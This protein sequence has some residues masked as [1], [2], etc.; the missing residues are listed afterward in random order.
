MLDIT[1]VFCYKAIMSKT[2]STMTEML[3]NAIK[4]SGLSAYRISQDTGLIVTSII[5][6]ANGETSLRLDKADLL[7][8]YFGL[9]VIRRKTKE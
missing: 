4:T 5:R 6:F 2:K 9:E 1:A 7:A 8:N 3:R